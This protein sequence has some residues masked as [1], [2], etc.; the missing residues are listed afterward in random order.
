MISRPTVTCRA[1]E[2][3]SSAPPVFVI[4]GAA[5]WPDGQASNAMRRRVKGALACATGHPEALFLVSGGVGKQPPS[6]AEVMSGLLTES[7]VSKHNI[8]QDAKSTTTLESVLNCTAILKELPATGSVLICTDVY[9][10][11]RCRWLFWLAGVPTLPGRVESGRRQNS[12]SR[13]IYYYLREVVALP[14]DTFLLMVSN[15]RASR[16]SGQ[17]I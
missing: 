11:P 6:E 15:L 5:V 16:S 10:I 1:T 3:A 12:I 2:L 14:W 8:L 13:W 9:H 7:G 17:L 4:M